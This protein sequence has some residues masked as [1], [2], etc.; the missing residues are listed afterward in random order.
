MSR[1]SGHDHQATG[2]ENDLVERI[3]SDPQLPQT[4][5][6]MLTSGEHRGDLLRCRELAISAYLVKPTLPATLLGSV[7]QV[8]GR[9]G[10][11]HGGTTTERTS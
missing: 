11:A 7:R 6:L 2:T 3:R 8:I 5:V 4:C 10:A 1:Y 9:E